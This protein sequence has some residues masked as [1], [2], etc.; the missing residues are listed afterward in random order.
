MIA[1]YYACTKFGKTI[2]FNIEKTS[3][4]D[5]PEIIELFKKVASTTEPEWFYTSKE[6]IQDSVLNPNSFPIIIKHEGKIVGFGVAIRTPNQIYP[7]C[8]D[9]Y[10]ANYNIP[11]GDYAGLHNIF[12]DPDYRGLGLQKA[13]IN[14]LCKEIAFC[15]TDIVIATVHPDNIFSVNNFVGTGF[16]MANNKPIDKF[17]SKRNYWIKII[18]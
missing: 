11:K 4:K 7:L 6:K 18:V 3:E 16:T 9:L 12:V 14:A 10:N 13:I 5:L 2:E 8:Q 17:N 1:S 15:G